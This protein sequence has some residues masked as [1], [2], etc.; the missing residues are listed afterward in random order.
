MCS[1]H[2]AIN[3]QSQAWTARASAFDSGGS[4]AMR[5]TAMR[6]DSSSDSDANRPT[7]CRRARCKPQRLGSLVVN[8]PGH[9]NLP[10]ADL[11]HP[12]SDGSSRPKSGR[13]DLI[14]Q[15]YA[16]AAACPCGPDSP[17]TPRRSPQHLVPASPTSAAF[18]ASTRDTMA[19]AQRQGRPKGQ[20]RPSPRSA[21]W[22]TAGTL[23]CVDAERLLCNDSC[24]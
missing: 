13:F 24:A 7:P 23:F 12:H 22:G 16:A 10:L 9:C 19:P 14:S 21:R 3:I 20:F 17:S 4:M 18:R 5:I 8:R 15:S 1:E 11:I 2:R 6:P